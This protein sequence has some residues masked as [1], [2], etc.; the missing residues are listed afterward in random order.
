MRSHNRKLETKDGGTIEIPFPA[1]SDRSSFF[2]FSLFK[3]GSTLLHKMLAEYCSREKVP[4]VDIPTR[5]FKAGLRIHMITPASME[6]A[7]YD[8]GYG[9]LGWRGPLY[10][11]NFDFSR[12]RNILLVR[13]PRDR[14]VSMYFSWAY[15]HV[16]PGAGEARDHLQALREKV[17]GFGSVNEW[18]MGDPQALRAIIAPLNR[19]HAMLPAETTRLYR[20]E[21]VIYGK[22]EWL[23]DML[24][25]MGVEVDPGLVDEIAVKNDLRP[26]S[27]KPDEHVRQVAP[28]NYRKHIT[29]EALDYLDDVYEEYIRAYGYDDEGSIAKRLVYAREG[30]EAASVLQPFRKFNRLI[31]ARK[32][33]KPRER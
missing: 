15:S 23:S 32:N 21:D 24:E 10:N 1:S 20:Y 25:F 17:L 33:A 26:E 12:T 19:F 7:L 4:A 9:Y 14:L 3:A 6:S 22:S 13:D 30:R 31:A 5:L 27:E 8:R 29:G 18:V 2:A 11:V 28:G 16:T